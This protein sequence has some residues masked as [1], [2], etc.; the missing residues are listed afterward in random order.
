MGVGSV[1][2]VGGRELKS[3]GGDD[4]ASLFSKVARMPSRGRR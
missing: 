3:E 4:G 1:V 2:V